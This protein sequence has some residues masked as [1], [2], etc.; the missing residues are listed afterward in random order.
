MCKRVFGID[1]TRLSRFLETDR[2]RWLICVK[3]TWLISQNRRRLDCLWSDTSLSRDWYVW[4]DL[5]GILFTYIS[6]ETVQFREVGSV[7]IMENN[8][9]LNLYC[10][11]YTHQFSIRIRS[12]SIRSV[13]DPRIFKFLSTIFS[14]LTDENCRRNGWRTTLNVFD[15]IKCC[16]IFQIQNIST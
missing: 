6:H 9:S 7:S 3:H 14:V 8:V 12:V 13:T 1:S 11:I 15:A 5:K 10:V 2:S 16:T 4:I